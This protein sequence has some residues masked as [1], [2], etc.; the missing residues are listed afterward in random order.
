MLGGTRQDVLASGAV[1]ILRSRASQ[2]QLI[3]HEKRRR[4]VGCA[5]PLDLRPG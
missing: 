5:L 2:G 4:S 3:E 1:Y